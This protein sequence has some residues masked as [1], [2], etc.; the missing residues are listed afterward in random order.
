MN[1]WRQRHPDH[2]AAKATH[3]DDSG[4]TDVELSGAA[5]SVY[6]TAAQHR[7][8]VIKRDAAAKARK[9]KGA[10]RG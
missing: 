5:E 7:A 6:D 9:K 10:R 4:S 1:K 8:G 2:K 3:D